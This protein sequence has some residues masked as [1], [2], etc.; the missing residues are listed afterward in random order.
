M[1][2]QL[3]LPSQ[4]EV[5]AWL[6]LCAFRGDGG[7]WLRPCCREGAWV[8]LRLFVLLGVT[9]RRELLGGLCGFSL[10]TLPAWLWLLFLLV[11]RGRLPLF[12]PPC[13]CWEA[14]VLALL[15]VPA[16]ALCVLTLLGVLVLLGDLLELWPRRGP[17]VL[18]RLRAPLCCCRR[19]LLAV[20]ALV[21]ALALPD[22]LALLWG[23]DF[24]LGLPGG[25]VFVLVGL[26][27]LELLGLT[28]VLGVVDGLVG[29]EGLLGVTDLVVFKEAGG[30]GATVGMEGP[31]EAGDMLGLEDLFGGEGMVGGKG[32]V[33]LDVMVDMKDLVAVGSD[34]TASHKPPA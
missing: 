15:A 14:G 9:A 25:A 1:S 11:A 13:F 18:P 31:V 6:W 23:W 20:L 27:D 34:L 17:G 10:L 12:P 3:W 16:L 26:V 24:L 30:V 32:L 4:R 29:L 8:R 28:T 21:S 19:T 5:S 2:D 33:A 22:S 7:D